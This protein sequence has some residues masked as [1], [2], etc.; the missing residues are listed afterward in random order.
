MERQLNKNNGPYTVIDSDSRRIL[1]R[2]RFGELDK[3]FLFGYSACAEGRDFL[4]L[5]S[6]MNPVPRSRS[7]L[8]RIPAGLVVCK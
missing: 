5:D 1:R 6:S 3:A 2:N 8:I 4:V 7:N